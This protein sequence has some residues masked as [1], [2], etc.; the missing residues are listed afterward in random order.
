MADRNE[1]ELGVLAYEPGDAA[2]MLG[3]GKTKLYEEIRAGRIQAKKLGRRTLIPV[4]VLY[5][6]IEKLESF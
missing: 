5:D 6:W 3:I 1:K 2:R 4:Q